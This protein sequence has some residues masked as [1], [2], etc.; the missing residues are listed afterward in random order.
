MIAL[1]GPIILLLIP[2]FAAVI[3][4][5]VALR[6]VR[7]AHAIATAACALSAA[8]A[9]ALLL[10]VV[11]TGTVHYRMAGW[12]APFGIELAADRM[13][14]FVAVVVATMATLSLAWSLRPVKEEIGRRGPIFYAVATLTLC[15]LLGMCVT[16]DAF[17]MFVFLEVAS[18]GGYALVGA[19]TG[20]SQIAAFRY[21]I[22]GAT[23]AS[24]Y[25]LGV[26]YL[27]VAT[28]SLNLA[29]LATL[30]E[31]NDLAPVAL[32]FIL[33]G[34]ALKMGLFPLHAWMP[35]AYA[36][37]PSATAA[38][39]A[40]IVT[41]VMAIALVRFLFTVFGADTFL[42]PIPVGKVLA[43]MGA[44]AAVA[45]AA[46]A[47]TQTDYRR[48]LAWSSV[49][50]IGYIAIGVGI[51]SDLAVAAALLHAMNHALMKG[52]LFY[53]AGAARVY[54]VSDLRGLFARMPVTAVCFLIAAMSLVGIPPLGGFFSKWYL[55]RGAVEAG[56]P[57]LAGAIVGGSLLA[58]L[59]VFKIVEA[60]WFRPPGGDEP[61][62]RAEAPPTMLIPLAI[63]AVAIIVTGLLSE[64]I[65]S[66]WLMGALG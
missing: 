1:H 51:G 54:R 45:G 33:A 39:V 10:R 55:L 2:L 36:A 38:F 15:G 29:D 19:G 21:L 16:G 3:I 8:T 25:L 41:K 14:T 26:G 56:Q 64:R 18:L 6:R 22:L 63:A 57:L 11:E 52:G 20:K 59:Y 66:G 62:E 44:I 34:L 24:L 47:A 46:V 9:W 40:P 60:A 58:V 43:W 27:Y 12:D 48:L 32:A 4:S 65:V 30:V 13:G 17:N 49:G 23:G 61:V 37:A 28:G 35:D 31:G 5:I 50:Q 42:G 53:V 7:L